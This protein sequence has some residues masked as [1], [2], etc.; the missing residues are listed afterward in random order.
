MTI[1][2]SGPSIFRGSKR[3]PLPKA[4]GSWHVAGFERVPMAGRHRH[5]MDLLTAKAAEWIYLVTD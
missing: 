4:C 1:Y 3:A 2:N 5:R